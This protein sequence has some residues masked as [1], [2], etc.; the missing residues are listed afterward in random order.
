MNGSRFKA[1]SFLLILLVLNAMNGSAGYPSDEDQNEPGGE[2]AAVVIDE[3]G[4]N[5]DVKEKFFSFMLEHPTLSCKLARELDI[6]EFRV[7]KSEKGPVFKEQAFK[8]YLKKVNMKNGMHKFDFSYVVG[9]DNPFPVKTTG[10]GKATIATKKGEDNQIK[11][12]I[13]IKL[14]PNDF[15]L[16]KVVKKIPFILKAVFSLKLEKVLR[17]AEKL[18]DYFVNDADYLLEIVTDEESIFTMSEIKA[19]KKYLKYEAHR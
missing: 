5:L 15:A 4:V 17:Q 18:G 16:D 13:G 19:L 10:K 9:I 8:I 11:A 1:A 7:E 2:K 14:Y 6:T 3:Q 12:D